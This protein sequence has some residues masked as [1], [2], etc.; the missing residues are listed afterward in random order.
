MS[1]ESLLK[2]EDHDSK[3]LNLVPKFYS[4]DEKLWLGL[5][6]CAFLAVQLSIFYSLEPK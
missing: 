6:Q 3:K 1:S 5:L 4:H 2:V